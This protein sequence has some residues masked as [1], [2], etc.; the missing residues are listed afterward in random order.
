MTK[1]PFSLQAVLD[2][3]EEQE[4]PEAA[5]PAEVPAK[6]TPP[7]RPRKPAQQPKTPQKS[8]AGRV[9]IGGHFLPDVSKQLAI[10]AAEEGMTKQVL[11]E[12][13]LDLLFVKKGKKRIKDL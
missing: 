12:E 4:E 9:L 5:T 11:L 7:K 6:E 13:A 2:R 1:K 3:H 8:R 10:L